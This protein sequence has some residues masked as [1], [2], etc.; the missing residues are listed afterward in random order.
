[1]ADYTPPSL[2]GVNIADGA[3]YPEESHTFTVFTGSPDTV[4]LSYYLDEVLAGTFDEAA[5]A[6]NH[7]VFVFTMHADGEDHRLRFEAEDRAG[8]KAGALVYEIHVGDDGAEKARDDLPDEAVQETLL[9][10]AGYEDQADGSPADSP[11]KTAEQIRPETGT[12]QPSENSS[13]AGG[14]AGHEGLPL[15]LALCL[16]FS[17]LMVLIPLIIAGKRSSCIR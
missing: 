7:G 15:P 4:R 9:Q 3:L 17:I 11:V 6:Q 13:D 12:R 16:I 14:E 5:L 8:Y 1:M 2:H 10:A